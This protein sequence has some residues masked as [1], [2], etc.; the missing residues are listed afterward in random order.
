MTLHTAKGLEFE[1]VF[2]MGLEEGLFPHMRSLNSPSAIEEE[3][4][5]MYVGVTRA[6]DRLYLTFSR[7]RMSFGGGGYASS[8]YTLPSRFLNEIKT[9]Y[10][11][12]YQPDPESNFRAQD[13]DRNRERENVVFL[14]DDTTF[15][16]QQKQGGKP[17]PARPGAAPKPPAAGKG[18]KPRVLSRRPAPQ[19][20]DYVSATGES[21]IQPRADF[22]RLSVG[23]KVS[24]TKFGIGTVD[25]VIGEQ[26]KELYNINFQASGKRLLDPRFAKLVKLD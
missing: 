24:H 23:D 25:Q 2:L 10:L 7:R 4:R 21:T 14:D 16:A 1:S 18:E 12:G 5:L 3:R 22:E 9:D 13:Q 17:G 11:T 15:G 20:S 26:D 8:N 6:E 19:P